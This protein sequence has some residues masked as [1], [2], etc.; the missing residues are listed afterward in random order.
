MLLLLRLVFL[1]APPSPASVAAAFGPAF[2]TPHPSGEQ[3]SQLLLPLLLNILAALPNIQKAGTICLQ[4]DDPLRRFNETTSSRSVTIGSLEK[5]KEYPA[6]KAERVQTKY[7][8]STLLTV[9]ESSVNAVCVFLPKRY[10]TVFS[11]ADIDA[12]NNETF[13]VDIPRRLRQ[14]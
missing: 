8:V 12:V 1:R 9:R 13:K 4:L 2:S 5:N 3:P 6:L 14:E 11:D 10:A 7:G